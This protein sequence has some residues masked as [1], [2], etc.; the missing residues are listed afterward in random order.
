MVQIINVVK[1]DTLVTFHMYDE[2]DRKKHTDEFHK[3]GDL[4]VC[5]TAYNVIF[6]DNG[7]MYDGYICDLCDISVDDV[8]FTMYALGNRKVREEY[9]EDCLEQWIYNEVKSGLPFARAVAYIVS[10]LTKHG[11]WKNEYLDI[12]EKVEDELGIVY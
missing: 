6:L 3:D 9:V 5:E 1:V 8:D 2:K 12:V 4:M 11:L 10:M 7:M